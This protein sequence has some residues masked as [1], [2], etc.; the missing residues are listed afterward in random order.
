MDSKN[1]PGNCPFSDQSPKDTATT[2]CPIA[3][4]AT[5]FDPFDQPFQSDPAQSLIWAREQNPPSTHPKLVI[6]SLVDTTMSKQ[7]FATIFCFPHQSY[8]KKLHPFQK[9]R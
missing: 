8:L 6:G 7:Y 5:E 9:R 2:D 1:E 3:N 4:M